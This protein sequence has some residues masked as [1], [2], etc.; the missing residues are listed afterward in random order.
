MSDELSEIWE[1]Y[2]EEGGRSLDTVE[3]TLLGLKR[4]PADASAVA[5]LFR[6]M[7]TFKGNARVMGLS[8]IEGRAHLAEDLIGL[9]RDEGVPLDAELIGLLL[10]ASD[11]LRGMLEG[12]LA[13]RGDAAASEAEELA[14]RIRG[15]IHRCRQGEPPA[16][17]VAAGEPTGAGAEEKAEAAGPP[18]F[19]EPEERPREFAD[20]GEPPLQAV[21]FEPVAKGSLADDP[22]YREIF[23]GMVH[24]V[25]REMRLVL[26]GFSAEP[27]AAA[28]RLAEEAERLRHA[29]EQ[30]GMDAWLAALADFLA[31]E[32]AGL[33]QAEAAIERLAALAAHDFGG[34]PAEAG[35]AGSAVDPVREFFDALEQPLAALSAVGARLADGQPVAADDLA[36][37]IAAIDAL[38]EPHGFVRLLE[39]TRRFVDGSRQAPGELKEHF[40]SLEFL[41]YEELAAIQDAVLADRA[42]I[43]VDALSILRN[44]C[45]ERV[46]DSLLEIG[47]A[48]DC[49]RKQGASAAHCTRINELMRHV[50]YACQYY[51]LETASHLS[52]ALVDLFARMLAGEMNPDAVLLRLARS[53]V[54]DMELVLDSVSSGTAP[55]LGLI[56][57]LL[58]EASDAAFVVGGT[59][60]SSQIE[61]RLGLPR[62]FHKVLTPDSVQAASA[63]LDAGRRFFIVRADLNSNEA[64]S[65][66]FLNWINSGAAQVVSNVTVFEGNRTLWD[67]LLATPLDAVRLG[68]ALAALDPAG[69]ALR[70]EMALLDRKSGEHGS[71]K[72]E[73]DALLKGPPVAEAMSGDMLESIGELVTG[74]AMVHHLLA[75]LLE[76][77]LARAVETELNKAGGNWSEAR[78]AVR[79]YLGNWQGRVEKLAQLEAQINAQLDRLQEQAIAVRMRPAALLLKPL[80]PFV[81]ALARQ[82]G[83]QVALVTDG[84]DVALDFSMMED[85]KAPLRTLVSFCVLQ[86]IDRPERREADGKPRQGRIRVALARRDDQVGIT[87]EDDGIGLSLERIAQ[88]ARQL[89]WEAGNSQVDWVLRDGFGVAGNTEAEPGDVD[90]AALRAALRNHGG[91]LRVANLPLGGACFSMTRPLAAVVREGMVVR[92]GA[93][94]YVVPIDGIQRI[95]RAGNE[96]LTRVSADSGRYLLCFGGNDVL[97]VQFLGRSGPAD[98]DAAPFPP[99]AAETV[100]ADGE[101]GPKHLFV[102][103]GKRSQRV[104]IPV[105][106]LIGQQQVLIRPLQGYLSGI[107]GVTGCALLGSGDVGMVLDIAYVLNQEMGMSAPRLGAFS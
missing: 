94:R 65:L 39:M 72:A 56:E 37:V 11:V 49:L 28:T 42:G 89:G 87:V 53:F 34:P 54:A 60:S 8:V 55:D 105:D 79:Q 58:Q 99:A 98:G 36:A 48:L 101:E 43:R 75:G 95:A 71:G 96:V 61:A 27:F 82:H 59:V 9:V 2:A 68:E 40:R 102:V 76:D 19:G 50:Y 6:A 15:K 47:N 107:R 97:P 74:Q 41:L 22:V 88:R 103:V 31:I 33:E 92:V 67:F 62:T 104:A 35:A 83:R 85:L 13:T 80:A 4:S 1:L 5:G 70:V 32:A 90:F 18:R 52:M 57:K 45:A 64:L 12:S 91:D 66:E 23:A 100:E 93:V 63:A 26:Q 20:D 38:A 81:D 73:D 21:V 30:M 78:G 51:G 17:P 3:E 46:F 29:A 106:E 86:S 25:L 24:D 84:D 7:H 77:D 69:E 14:E 16:E 10:E 44:W